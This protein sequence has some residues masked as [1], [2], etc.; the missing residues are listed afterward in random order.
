MWM[1]GRHAVVSVSRLTSDHDVRLRRVR[2]LVVLLVAVA[3]ASAVLEDPSNPEVSRCHMY[4]T[5]TSHTS[6]YRTTSI[7]YMLMY[8]ICERLY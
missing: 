8:D 1:G 6:V 3:V 7:L 5:H 2:P 4:Y